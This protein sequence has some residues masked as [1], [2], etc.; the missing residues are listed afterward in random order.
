MSAQSAVSRFGVT[1]LANVVRAGCSFAGGMVLARALGASHY[2]DLSFLLGSFAAASQLLD[3]GTSNAFFTLIAARRRPRAVLAWYGGW[4]AAQ[5]AILLLVVG[6]LLP[7]PVIERLWVGHQ[8]GIVLVACAASFVTTQLWNAVSQLGEAVRRTAMVQCAVAGQAALHLLLLAIGARHGWLSVSAVFWLLIAEYALLAAA[9]APGLLRDNWI[10]QDGSR[11]GHQALWNEFITYC[12]PLVLY[13][14]VGC[15]YA[16]TDQ[17]LLQRFGGS[18]QQGFFAVA[19]Q[20]TV[21]S[22]LLTTSVL[23]VFWKEIVDASERQDQQQ[24]QRL[25]LSTARWLYVVAAWV[26]CLVM[27][28]SR[29]LLGLLLGPAYEASWLCLAML[30]LYP[31]HQ[32]LGQ[33]GATFLYATKQTGAYVWIGIGMMLLSLPTTY[34]LLA[35]LKLGAVGLALKLVVLQWVGVNLQIAVIAR[36]GGA[37][38]AWRHQFAVLAACAGFGWICKFVGAAVAGDQSAGIAMAVGSLLYASG[39][40]AALLRWPRLASLREQLQWLRFAGKPPAVS[41]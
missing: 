34:L 5:C 14:W 38:F 37:G 23:K 21:V 10:A 41:A 9:M 11:S 40:L 25:Y 32:A 4:L 6:V 39:S 33:I 13:S 36:S 35:W 27:P 17:W 28:Y 30:L 3:G 15:V 20:F 12:K 24:V 22:L 31:A 18:A 19:Q 1:V 29:E 16:F 2:G 8:Q 7:R 26:S